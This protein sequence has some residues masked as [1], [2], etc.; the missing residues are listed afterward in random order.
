M[1]DSDA[2]DQPVPGLAPDS[3]TKRGRLLYTLEV[4]GEVF[5]VRSRDGGTDYDW[6][7]GPNVDYGFSTSER[8]IPE[9][10]QRQQIRD[11]LGWIDP[12]TGYLGP[13]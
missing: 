6:V 4:D 5:D 2:G 9:E 10:R 13:D 11:F 1:S 12:S 7:S 8:D 3:T